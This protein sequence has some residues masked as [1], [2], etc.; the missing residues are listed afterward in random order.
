MESGPLFPRSS[1]LLMPW[2]DMAI[3]AAAQ[4]CPVWDLKTQKVP[5]Q[6]TKFAAEK[7]Y[8]DTAGWSGCMVFTRTAIRRSND[9]YRFAY[10]GHTCAFSLPFIQSTCVWIDAASDA[11]RRLIRRR[12]RLC[13]LARRRRTRIHENKLVFGPNADVFSDILR[14]CL[15]KPVWKVTSVGACDPRFPV[16]PLPVTSRSSRDL[17]GELF[18]PGVFLRSSLTLSPCLYTRSCQRA[19]NRKFNVLVISIVNANRVILQA[20]ISS[21]DQFGPR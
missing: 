6:F 19:A 14:N 13:S 15:S 12:R 9:Q 10:T 2:R 8:Y 20:S 7:L 4:K 5:P 21:S 18:A 16:W 11:A 3:S 1:L 17:T